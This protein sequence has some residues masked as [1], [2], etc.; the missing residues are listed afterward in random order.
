MAFIMKNQ[1]VD[2]APKLMVLKLVIIAI[3]MIKGLNVMI[4][5]L[6]FMLLNTMKV[7]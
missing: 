5:K 2:H 7:V 6:G 3:W 1:F 4:V